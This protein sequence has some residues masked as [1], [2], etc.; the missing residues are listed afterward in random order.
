MS[1]FQTKICEERKSREAVP[2]VHWQIFSTGHDMRLTPSTLHSCALVSCRENNRS[3]PCIYFY[4]VHVEG[5]QVRKGI[6]LLCLLSPQPSPSLTTVTH[7][8]PAEQAALSRAC[9]EVTGV[10]HTRGVKMK[11]R[12]MKRKKE[13]EG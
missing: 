5:T 10:K 7:G 3:G 6:L 13:E 1:T 12:R 8:V 2:A 9:G 11:K 4:G